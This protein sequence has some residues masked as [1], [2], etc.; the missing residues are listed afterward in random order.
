MVARGGRLML[1]VYLFVWAVLLFVLAS[2][3]G[4]I[5]Y[6]CAFYYEYIF[7]RKDDGTSSLL[8]PTARKQDVSPD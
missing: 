2:T 8:E 7:G 4:A 6:A 5:L 3:L 1:L